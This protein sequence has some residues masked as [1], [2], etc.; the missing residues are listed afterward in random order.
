[1]TRNKRS[2]KIF[3]P[4]KKNFCCFQISWKEKKKSK[5]G[6]LKKWKFYMKISWNLKI[7]NSKFVTKNKLRGGNVKKKNNKKNFLM[8]E[9][10]WIRIS[11][12]WKKWKSADCE[13]KRERERERERSKK[14][15]KSE[16]VRRAEKK[17]S[18]QKIFMLNFFFAI[19]FWVWL[20]ELLEFWWK[21]LNFIFARKILKIENQSSGSSDWKLCKIWWLFKIYK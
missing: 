20:D 17:F 3:S 5:L 7:S 10:S 18:V 21:M 15:E 11:V 2:K 8:K 19:N 1:V 9:K 14:N 4:T 12:K 16:T 13:K 6:E